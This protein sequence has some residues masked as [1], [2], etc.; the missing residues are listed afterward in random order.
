M[1]N[2][3]AK[4]CNELSY[5]LR[6]PAAKFD[7]DGFSTFLGVKRRSLDWH[8]ITLRANEEDG[9][10][11]H[12]SWRK[13]KGESENVQLQADFHRW[14]PH[15]KTPLE[16]PKADALYEAVSDFTAIKGGD[17]HIHAEFVLRSE[18]WQLTVLPIPW[19]LPGGEDSPTVDGISFD[20]A[21]PREGVV[22]GFAQVNSAR[23]VLQLYATRKLKFKSFNI[24]TDIEAFCTVAKGLVGE[25]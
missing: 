10:H 24:E 21:V 14:K 9:F 1:A 4:S 20:L 18:A 13:E 16:T 7:F 2:E 12:V 5:R 25:K 8:R 23:L 15:S 22:G 3:L 17:V 19:K 6:L 11:C